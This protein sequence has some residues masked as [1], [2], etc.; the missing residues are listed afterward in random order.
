MAICARFRYKVGGGV[1]EEGEGRDGVSNTCDYEDQR[2]PFSLRVQNPF[3]ASEQLASIDARLAALLL[4]V[5]DCI[6]R[7]VWRLGCNKEEGGGVPTRL[8]INHY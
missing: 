3:L 1:E 7:M 4:A 8:S 5:D 6:F 2:F